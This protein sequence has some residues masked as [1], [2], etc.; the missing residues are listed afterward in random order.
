MKIDFL[1]TECAY[2]AQNK[3]SK[4]RGSFTEQPALLQGKVTSPGW[5]RKEDFDRSGSGLIKLPTHTGMK[6]NGSKV[7]SDSNAL[8]CLGSVI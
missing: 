6:V 8:P 3:G 4:K 2:S 5:I 1:T 7:C